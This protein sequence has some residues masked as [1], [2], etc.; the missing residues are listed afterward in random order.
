L[1]LE[2]LADIVFPVLRLPRS[3]MPRFILLGIASAGVSVA[4]SAA[5]ELVVQRADTGPF[6]HIAFSHHGHLLAISNKDQVFV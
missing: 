3:L 2:H 5:P 4:P 6:P 1:I